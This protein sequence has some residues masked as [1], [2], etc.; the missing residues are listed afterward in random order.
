MKA[1]KGIYKN[2]VVTLLEPADLEDSAE[3]F[4]LS[5]GEEKPCNEVKIKPQPVSTLERIEGK[6]SFGGN[7]VE[8]A[9]K[10]YE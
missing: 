5:R 8:D 10:Y 2:G 7:A 9:E 3:V 1:I 6:F 4:V